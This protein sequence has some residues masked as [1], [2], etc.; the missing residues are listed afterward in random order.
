ML[1]EKHGIS[2]VASMVMYAVSI[3][4]YEPTFFEK[5]EDARAHSRTCVEAGADVDIYRLSHP[6]IDVMTAATSFGLGDGHL[7]ETLIHRKAVPAG[8][9]MPSFWSGREAPALQG[10]QRA[11]A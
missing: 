10:P 2:G 8:F 4:G 7:V 1:A 6:G 11:Y 3:F 5:I 9:P